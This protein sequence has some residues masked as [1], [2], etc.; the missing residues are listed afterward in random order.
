MQDG[1]ATDY[2]LPDPD[3]ESDVN[4]LQV[5]LDKL[6]DAAKA[7]PAPG[8]DD[9]LARRL[10]HA[11]RAPAAAMLAAMWS[12]RVAE[13]L[14]S[15][16]PALAAA[17]HAEMLNGYAMTEGRGIPNLVRVLVYKAV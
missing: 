14:Q 6:E 9:A 17:A 2:S 4:D 7:T 10:S 12:P 13:P 8:L 1:H 5:A 15:I 3:M 16:S 11:T